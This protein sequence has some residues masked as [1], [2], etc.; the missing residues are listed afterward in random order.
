MMAIS[1]VPVNSFS[2]K[3]T[4]LPQAEAKRS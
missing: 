2:K 4:D 1:F 3:P